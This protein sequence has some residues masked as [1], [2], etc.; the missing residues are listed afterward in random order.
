MSIKTLATLK[1][2]N[3]MS[4]RRLIQNY[5][6][7]A[8][9]TVA[10][11]KRN[12]AEY[13]TVP[14][15]ADDSPPGVWGQFS[16]VFQIYFE[17]VSVRHMLES[18]IVRRT[19]LPASSADFA[20]FAKYRP[21]IA[22]YFAGTQVTE[23]IENLVN[24]VPAAFTGIEKEML[25]IWLWSY[26]WPFYLFR[27]HIPRSVVLETMVV[28]LGAGTG[29]FNLSIGGG[30]RQRRTAIFDL[31]VILHLQQIVAEVLRERGVSV[32]SIHRT[33]DVNSLGEEIAEYHYGVMSYWAFNEFPLELRDKFLP[34]LQRSAFSLFASNSMFEGVDNRQ[35]FEKL[36]SQLSGKQVYFEKIDWH[37]YSGHT[38]VLIK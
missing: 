27:E 3:Y 29:L 28:E 21:V 6:R 35:Y 13:R 36:T 12:G 5:I 32:P 17:H 10:E 11:S 7:L 15:C 14:F 16:Q 33:S 23:S 4:K 31:P 38:Y 18:S 24:T 19:M 20:R 30:T 9:R 37:P 25:D 8:F 2:P 22:E 34:L 1:L 26:F